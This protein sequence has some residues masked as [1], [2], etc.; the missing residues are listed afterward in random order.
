[1]NVGGS[2]WRHPYSC[3]AIASLIP[4]SSSMPSWTPPIR[5]C[6]SHS[7]STACCSPCHTCLLLPVSNENSYVFSPKKIIKI[8][9]C[10]SV[11]LQG[12]S[13]FLSFTMVQNHVTYQTRLKAPRQSSSVTTV[14][15]ATCGLLSLSLPVRNFT[16]GLAVSWSA[17]SSSR[18]SLVGGGGG[19]LGVGASAAV[20]GSST[21]TSSCCC[22]A[23]KAYEC[24]ELE[25]GDKVTS[26]TVDGLLMD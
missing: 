7:F 3:E 26:S 8:N 14:C 19:W 2:C 17:R 4:P 20:I 18:G 11:N 15:L 25:S 16:D 6:G 5:Q 1:M 21:C 22:P 10:Q 24:G 13:F 9:I 23:N 12:P